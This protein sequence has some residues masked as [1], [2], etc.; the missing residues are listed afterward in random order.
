MEQI[1]VK[2]IKLKL[3]IFLPDA[4]RAVVKSL[5][6][7]DIKN[8]DIE[9][10]VVNTLHLADRPG[11]ELLGK[12]GGIKKFMN[13][14]GLVV[15]DSG[16]W[17][18]FSLIHRSK[19][20]GKITDDGVVFYAGTNRKKIFSPEESVRTQFSI[21]SDVII[22]LDDFTP[23]DA[24]EVQIREGVERTVL[25]ARKGKNEYSRLIQ[26]QG[27]TQENRPL[28]FSV[29]QGGWDKELRR[30]CAEKLVEIGFD[31]YGYGGYAIDDNNNLDLEFSDFTAK[32]IPDNAYKFALGTGKPWELASLRKS[33]WDIFDC[34]LP[35]RD[36]RH[37]RMYIFKYDPA[38]ANLCDRDNFGF[39]DIGRTVYKDDMSPV[40]PY[41]DCLTCK[42]Y[43][44]AYLHHLFKTTDITALRLATIHNLRH[45]MKVI[46]NIRCI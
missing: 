6:S 36:A 22:C 13:F 40:D 45:Y 46:E 9:G 2:D 38:G 8:I 10:V 20:P 19:N 12:V 18:I 31:G 30:Y 32:L 33:G 29:I 39:I 16:G 24:L 26:E 21:G 28:L 44:K 23:P 43:T 34:T 11:L 41:C 4:T 14:D 37:Q 5:D 17:Q 15:S 42:N 25:W 7:I 35:T 3:P 27:Y 1:R